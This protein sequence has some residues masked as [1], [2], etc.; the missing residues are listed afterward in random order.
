M[1]IVRKKLNRY[2]IE[3][4]M[5]FTGVDG[6]FDMTKI[7]NDNYTVTDKKTILFCNR[8]D[9]VYK[10]IEGSPKTIIIELEVIEELYDIYLE[11]EKENNED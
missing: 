1:P 5:S 2:N 6:D 10:K 9:I 3:D 11:K 4:V 7:G 8:N